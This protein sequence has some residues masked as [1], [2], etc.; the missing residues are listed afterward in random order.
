MASRLWLKER[1]ATFKYTATDTSTD[2]MELERLVL[3]MNITSSG[4]SE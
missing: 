3:E 4:P 1:F 2:I